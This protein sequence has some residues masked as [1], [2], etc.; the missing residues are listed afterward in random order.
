M[1]GVIMVLFAVGL[2]IYTMLRGA[3]EAPSSS[4]QPAPVAELPTRLNPSFYHDENA[5]MKI[6]SH[7]PYK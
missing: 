6:V 5:F 4:D 3:D 7:L 1:D 2:T